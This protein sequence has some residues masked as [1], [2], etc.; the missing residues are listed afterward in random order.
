MSW[1][2]VPYRPA[3]GGPKLAQTSTIDKT[4]KSVVA[5]AEPRLRE[6]IGEE[7]ARLANAV[8]IALP[9]AGISVVTSLATSYLIPSASKNAKIVGY[10]LSIATL[11]VGVWQAV[12]A[13]AKVEKVAV[14]PPA[15]SGTVQDI[16]SSLTDSASQQFAAA[17]VAA[18]EPRVRQIIEEERTRAS[19]VVQ[20]LVVWEAAAIAA[21]LGTS[22]LVPEDVPALKAGGYLVSAGS[23]LLGMYQAAE[24]GREERQAA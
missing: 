2:P 23:A 1:T 5:A 16:L 4:A 19:D 6:V 13:L 3:L 24:V 17:I 12:E 22:Y 21:F 8:L 10:G 20:T 18:A 14:A 9:Y 11:G 7:R 15:G